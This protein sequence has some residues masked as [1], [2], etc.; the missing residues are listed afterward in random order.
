MIEHRDAIV[1]VESSDQERRLRGLAVWPVANVTACLLRC[2]VQQDFAGVVGIRKIRM[3]ER[4]SYCAVGLCSL[5]VCRKETLEGCLVH[6]RAR[7]ARVQTKIARWDGWLACADGK[8][9][10]RDGPD[11]AAGGTMNRWRRRIAASGYCIHQQAS[12]SE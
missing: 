8:E 1:Q 12:V 3:S 2:D 6:P 4:S 5:S 10:T 11:G 7:P 9:M